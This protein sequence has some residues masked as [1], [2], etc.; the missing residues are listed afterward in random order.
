MKKRIIITALSIL[1]ASST[2]MPA[3]AAGSSFDLEYANV[4]QDWADQYSCLLY[5]SPLR[6]QGS[7]P[8][9]FR[10]HLAKTFIT[11]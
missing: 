10:I 7:L 5:T 9:L 2:V 8:Q 4:T 11:L 3:Y 6:I 1:L